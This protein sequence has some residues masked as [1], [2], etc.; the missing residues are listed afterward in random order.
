M[1]Q[2]AHLQGVAD[3][4]TFEDPDVACLKPTNAGWTDG[5]DTLSYER[6]MWRR[7]RDRSVLGSHARWVGDEVGA[8]V[9]AESEEIAEEALRLIK[10]DWEVLPVRS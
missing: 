3:V 7:F 8:V 1:S 5:V 6:M 10:V 4:L 2:A 9:A